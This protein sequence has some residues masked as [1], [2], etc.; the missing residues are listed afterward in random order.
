[1][2]LAVGF[3]ATR[4]KNPNQGDWYKLTKLL[5][6]LYATVDDVLT[7]E[8]EDCSKLYFFM[9]AAFAVHDDMRSQSGM[10]FSLGKGALCSGSNIQKTNTRSSTS[11]ELQAV[12]DYISTV[13]WSKRFMEHQGHEVTLCVVFQDNTSA[14][15]LERNGKASCGKRTRH[16]DIKYF[17]VTDLI[18]RG[19]IEVLYCPTDQMV[20]DFMTKPQVGTKFQV[21]RRVIMNLDGNTSIFDLPKLMPAPSTKKL[22]SR[23]VLD[24]RTDRLRIRSSKPTRISVLKPTRQ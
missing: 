12:D 8:A 21:F 17:F 14:I 15:K 20:A 4:V 9:D 3:L 10:N 18:N 2:E 24:G 23:S 7:L 22:S 19:E 16:F 13:L 6:F 5:G 11:A 1:M